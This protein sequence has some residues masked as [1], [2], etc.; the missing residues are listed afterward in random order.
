M[1][2]TDVPD[3]PLPATAGVRKSLALG[4]ADGRIR[5]S[6]GWYYLRRGSGNDYRAGATAGL[7]G[8]RATVAMQQVSRSAKEC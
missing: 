2:S 3:V 1:G 5:R 8:G 7:S 4:I 6:G